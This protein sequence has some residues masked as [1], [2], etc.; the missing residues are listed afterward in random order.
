MTELA[1]SLSVSNS[2]KASEVVSRSS[3]Y[4][5]V[6][7][8]GSPVDNISKFSDRESCMIMIPTDEEVPGSWVSF[9]FY[10]TP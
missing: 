7:N 9:K 4:L 8:N 1:T 5:S 2:I 6:V 10:Q 3:G